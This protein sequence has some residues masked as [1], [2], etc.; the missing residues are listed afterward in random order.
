MTRRLHYYL[1]LVPRD[2]IIGLKAAFPGERKRRLSRDGSRGGLLGQIPQ[3]R[4]ADSRQG[5]P[6]EGGGQCA[7]PNRRLLR[8]AAP[9]FQ[10][11]GLILFVLLSV[12]VLAG[13]TGRSLISWK[14]GWS[15]S[16][17]SEGVVYVG[18]RQGDIWALDA[19]QSRSGTAVD[20]VK[21]RFSPVKD[22]RLGG[23]FGAPAVGTEFIYV[24]DKGD[25]DG[26]NG[27]LYALR[28]DRES[29]SDV[30]LD[31]GEWVKLILGGI[32]GGPALAEAEGL[33]LVGS[34]DGNLYAFETTGDAIGRAW[35][36]PTGG[37]IWS[38][39]VVE[40]GVVYFGSM[41]HYVYAVSLDQGT[42]LWKY[43]TGGAVV[44]TPLLLDGLV[45]VG[46]FDRKLYA[47]KANTSSR[48]GELVWPQPFEGDDWFW[49]G[50]VSDGEYIFAPS[51]DGTVYAVDKR[52]DPIWL[53]PFKADSPIVSTPVIV[54][55]VGK[56]DALVVAT[57]S[58][59]L[60]LLSSRTGEKLAVLMDLG[61]RIKA[62]LS[63]EGNMVFVGVEKDA[64]VGVNVKRWGIPAWRVSTKK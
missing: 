52:G 7:N 11:W 24:G 28:K 34:D 10:A 59:Q 37:Q 33:V 62:P 55:G 46:S 63:R 45:I 30:R 4:F 43:R 9:S 18:T 25:R 58:G 50:P 13:C 29:N 23:V 17:V 36:F 41:D 14:P 44:S 22:D 61:S 47:L 42:L 53:V 32:V 3:S 49:A 6:P 54:E 51:M 57:D 48:E 2:A 21:W 16:A 60:Y 56:D 31:K 19:N 38:T 27:R 12:L 64:V 35:T 5:G 20:Q 15:G 1:R 8:N 39:P 40:D 26:E